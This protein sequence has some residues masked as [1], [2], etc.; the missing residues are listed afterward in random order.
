M[1]PAVEPRPRRAN[2]G[3]GVERPGTPKGTRDRQRAAHAEEEPQLLAAANV[4]PSPLPGEVSQGLASL[5]VVEPM[6]RKRARMVGTELPPEGGGFADG[7]D[8]M[9]SAG[10]CRIG[11]HNCPIRAADAPLTVTPASGCAGYH[12]LRSPGRAPIQSEGMN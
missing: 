1:Q 3:L 5:D 8:A 10:S 6:T 7:H 4:P 12:G 2:P 9:V 11:E